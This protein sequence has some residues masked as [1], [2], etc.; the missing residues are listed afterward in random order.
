MYKI[1]VEIRGRLG[2]FCS[3][4]GRRGGMG[5]TLNLVDPAACLWT[6]GPFRS[7]GR[8]L[9]G[10]PLNLVDLSTNLLDTAA[11]L[12]TR[13]R[14][15]RFRSVGSRLSGPRG[16]HRRHPELGGPQH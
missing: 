4:G 3:V 5:A 8:R 9:G 13:G 6:R 2:H 10:P 16:W 15:G 14:L 12:W 7:I 1:K 11:S